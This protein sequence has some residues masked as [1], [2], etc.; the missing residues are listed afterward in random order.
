MNAVISVRARIALLV[1]GER[2]S[3]ISIDNP[4]VE[5]PRVPDEFRY[6]FGEAKDLQCIDNIDRDQVAPRLLEAV[7]NDNALFVANTLLEGELPDDIRHEAATELE[8]FL[9]ETN[10]GEYIESVLYAEPRTGGADIAGALRICHG[11]EAVLSRDFVAKLRDRQ[12]AIRSVHDSFL[13]LPEALFS[14]EDVRARYRNIL[15]GERLYRALVEQITAAEPVEMFLLEALGNSR[16][17]ELPR[18]RDVLTA[19]LADFNLGDKANSALSIS[20]RGGDPERKS[21]GGRTPGHRSA[22]QENSGITEKLEQSQALYGAIAD[23]LSELR[24]LA[25]ECAEAD[26]DGYGAIGIH[27]LAVQRAEGFIRTLPQCVDLPEFAPEPDGAISLDWIRSKDRLF[28]LSIGT[29]NR[30][31]YT[32]LDG[33]DKGHAVALFNGSSIPPRILQGIRAIT[34][35]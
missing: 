19:W 30:L 22:G 29:T 32:W 24:A 34:G 15:T 2:L 20:A 25:G 3:S 35:G 33:T 7:E 14:S 6:L 10:A 26:W 17:A 9:A 8:E 13:K 5:T 18:H 11:V 21:T 27:P 12:P 31:S 1:D 28:S 4:D 16:V 23:A